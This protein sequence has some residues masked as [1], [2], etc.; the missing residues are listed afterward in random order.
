MATGALICSNLHSQDNQLVFPKNG[1]SFKAYRY[2]IDSS[3]FNPGTGG[4]G[5]KWIANEPSGAEM[6]TV[7][8]SDASTGQFA[9]DFPNADLQI[10]NDFVGVSD[11]TNAQEHYHFYRNDGTSLSYIGRIDLDTTTSTKYHTSFGNVE[12]K[13]PDVV[14][15]GQ[16]WSD[17]WDASYFDP[18]ASVTVYLSDGYTACQTDG[19]GEL[20]IG[21]RI[22]TGVFRVKRE[23]EYIEKTSITTPD[24]HRVVS[25]EWWSNDLPFPVYS[26]EHRHTTKSGIKD[27][28]LGYFLDSLHFPLPAF[29][30]GNDIGSDIEIFP[31]PAGR[32]INIAFSLKRQASVRISIVDI[33]GRSV[34][35]L[36]NGREEQGDLVRAVLELSSGSYLVKTEVDGIPVTRPLYVN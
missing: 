19:S 31:N 9:A 1:E 27:S 5:M 12:T 18:I 21:G 20:R 10:V 14:Y 35:V 6:F 3:D 7:E 24:T 16:N 15:Y 29:V 30:T 25:Y 26:I 22:L 4:T 33:N 28:Y 23:R 13:N 2:E 36:Y 11:F 34:Q 17:A 8:V 32:E